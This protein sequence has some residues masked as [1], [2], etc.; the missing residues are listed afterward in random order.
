MSVGSGASLI[1]GFIRKTMLFHYSGWVY[2]L[3]KQFVEDSTLIEFFWITNM[4][5]VAQ[6]KW[7]LLLDFIFD[8]N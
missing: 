6:T 2:E 7:F 1:K 4:H 5:Q 3:F 8:N